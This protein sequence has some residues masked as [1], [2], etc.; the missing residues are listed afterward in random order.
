MALWLHLQHHHTTA[1]T[2]LAGDTG[3]IQAI[4]LDVPSSAEWSVELSSAV[5]L[6]RGIF[7]V[8]RID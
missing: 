6:N 8:V 1:N 7:D 3:L 4:V 2:V 5:A